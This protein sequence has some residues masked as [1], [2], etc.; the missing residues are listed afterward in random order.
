MS[1]MR[2]GVARGEMTHDIGQRRLS[3]QTF[4]YRVHSEG[5]QFHLSELLSHNRR[6]V[7]QKR[8]FRQIY[9]RLPRRGVKSEESKMVTGTDILGKHAPRKSPLSVKKIL[10]I[11]RFTP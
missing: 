11:F 5:I 4:H 2:R 3:S 10:Q 9:S 1:G 7:P 6:A 8:C